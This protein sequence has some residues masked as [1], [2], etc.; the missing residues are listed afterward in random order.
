MANVNSVRMDSVYIVGGG[1]WVANVNSVIKRCFRWYVIDT[2]Q[3][4][5]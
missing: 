1:W 5:V 2:V 3:S 4:C